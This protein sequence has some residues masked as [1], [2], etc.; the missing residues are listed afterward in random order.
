MTQNT[1]PLPDLLDE[2]QLPSLRD[3][4]RKF[5]TP[6]VP[7]ATWQ[8]VN[9]LVPYF[10]LWVAMYFARSAAW[11]VIAPMAVLAGMLLVRAFIIF[12]DCGHGSFFPSKTANTIVGWITGILT[13]TPYHH[14]RREHSIHHATSG[15]LDERGTGDIWTLT[16]REYLAASRWK[17]LAYRLVRNPLVLFGLGPLF[18][19]IIW[20]RFAPANTRPRE[21]REVHLTNLALL[22]IAIGGS[23]VFGWKTYL[24]LQLS[25]MMVAGGLGLWM[26]YVQHQFEDG[27]WEGDSAWD[28]TAAAMAGSSYYKLPRILQ[29]F[30]GNIGFHHIHHLNSRIPN[31]N[32]EHCHS[33][34]PEFQKVKPVT[35]FSS[36][37]TLRL[38]LWDE[39]QRTMVGYSALRR[40]LPRRA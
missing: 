26:F 16:V 24:V 14:W 38:R 11:W 17:K 1:A 21:R 39:E 29:W 8:L 33:V 20:Q 18:I 9:T 4:S 6:S 7:R 5:E 32:L 3:L 2:E 28:Y 31:Y 37:R 22:L 36:L 30:S 35:L 10:G 23:W 13:F 25:V 27:Y 34:N 15:N 40:R 19:F 12:H